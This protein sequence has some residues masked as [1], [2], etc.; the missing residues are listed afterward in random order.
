L[1]RDVERRS[2]GARGEAYR[3]AFDAARPAEAAAV[4]HPEARER[5]A[6]DGIFAVDLGRPVADELRAG[7][8]FGPDTDGARVRTD[9]AGDPLGASRFVAA[10]PAGPALLE[11]CAAALYADATR[12]AI[13]SCIG[14]AYTVPSL[15]VLRTLAPED[16]ALGQPAHFG[17]AEAP[18]GFVRGILYLTDGA[19]DAAPSTF[20]ARN[21][22]V[23]RLR[24]AAGQ[25]ILYDPARIE[26][27]ESEPGRETVD[28]FLAPVPAG[29]SRR[30][31]SAGSN[32]YW[33][34]DP[35]AF[36]L[37]GLTVH[38]VPGG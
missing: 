8:A 36:A 20:A 29:A 37:D 9:W 32:H 28:V 13:A 31:V 35:N 23:A 5:F 1:L 15:R 27:R 18:P 26:H 33:P 30:V 25:L 16:R 12:A 38:E 10:A 24:P 21:G 7:L 6:R 14:S 2:G 19:L 11:R 3:A 4:P 34:L 17:M 22:A